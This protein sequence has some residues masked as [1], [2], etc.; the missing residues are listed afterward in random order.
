MVGLGRR[1]VVGEGFRDS[2]DRGGAPFCWVLGVLMLVL[3]LASSSALRF[4]PTAVDVLMAEG[5]LLAV[6]FSPVIS[7]NKSEICGDTELL[8]FRNLH[9]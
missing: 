4:K 1:P 6:A 9:D 7:A 5:A 3:V 2:E 8:T